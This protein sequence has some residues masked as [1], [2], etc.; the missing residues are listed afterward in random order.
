MRS[1]FNDKWEEFKKR[2][3]AFKAWFAQERKKRQEQRRQEY[4]ERQAARKA[5][6]TVEKPSKYEMEVY[7]CEQVLS[8]L[9][10]FLGTEKAAAPEKKDVEAPAPG[11][12]LLSKKGDGDEDSLFTGMGGK[13]GRGARKAAEKLQ[14]KATDVVK[15][16]PAVLP[17]ET[18]KTFLKM[19]I[20]A[21]KGN[22]D[23]PRAIADVEAKKRDYEEKR[24][25]AAAEPEPEEEEAEEDAKEEQEEEAGVEDDGQEGGKQE[26]NKDSGPDAAGPTPAEAN[27][28][29]KAVVMPVTAGKD[30]ADAAADGLGVKLRITDDG[31]VSME[32]KATA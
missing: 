7:T 28:G 2:D 5:R 24:D 17:L 16:L 15:K 1:A 4:E 19:G 29:V 11:M 25:K 21:P 9:R 8:Y 27:G 10:Q 31:E 3:R 6:E 23:V 32:V 22:D 14:S 30:G 26:S 20:E 18:L 13:K 12:K